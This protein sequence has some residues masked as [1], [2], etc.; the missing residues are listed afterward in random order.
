MAFHHHILLDFDQATLHRFL[1]RNTQMPP[2]K[3]PMMPAI[4][5]ADLAV[6]RIGLSN[7]L[8]ET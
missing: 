4:Q 3:I 8:S 7:A 1:S 2:T 5:S 6:L